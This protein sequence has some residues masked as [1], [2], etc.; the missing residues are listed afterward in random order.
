MFIESRQDY[1]KLFENKRVGVV[2]FNK[3]SRNLLRYQ[4]AGI[5]A[6]DFSIEY[7]IDLTLSYRPN[8]R[9]MAEE[10]MVGK[11]IVSDP[12]ELKDIL[13]NNRID[14]LLCFDR[15]GSVYMPKAISDFQEAYKRLKLDYDNYTGESTTAEY[16]FR[17]RVDVVDYINLYA[18]D[19]GIQVT[20]AYWNDLFPYANP[21][22][23]VSQTNRDAFVAARM[24]EIAEVVPD[25]DP[26]LDEANVH[27]IVGSDWGAGKT[28]FLFNRMKEG[29][30]G[31][32]GDSWFA[33][34]SENFIP[35]SVDPFSIKG[36]IVSEIRRAW[37]KSPQGDIYVKL[38]G[39]L[40]EYVYGIPMDQLMVIENLHRYFQNLKFDL[41]IKQK[42]RLED[43]RKVI[44]DF[45]TH[46][47][48]VDNVLLH[49]MDYDGNEQSLGPVNW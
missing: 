1:Y 33:L 11:K 31:I 16:N 5:K 32:A 47:D 30:Q 36:Y 14:M 44:S 39:R 38:G 29:K 25:L 12:N 28:S 20:S 35:E 18:A 49:S 22:I 8:I 37:M 23:D 3:D 48:A 46:Y 4:N 9:A 24:L 21:H 15:F 45:Q 34:V 2:T 26:G 7:L 40:E 13:D 42:Q 6:A 17:W 10:V 27:F 19:R 41:V 43:L